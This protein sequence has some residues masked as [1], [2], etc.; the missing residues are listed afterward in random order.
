MSNEITGP[1][2][3]C[4]SQSLIYLS[5]KISQVEGLTCR[6]TSTESVSKHLRYLYAGFSCECGVFVPEQI[7]ATGGLT[8]LPL[9]YVGNLTG[10]YTSQFESI[11]RINFKTQPLQFTLKYS[12]PAMPLQ[13]RA[14]AMPLKRPIPYQAP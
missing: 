5:S 6:I 9:A 3:S 11:R 2:Y 4:V 13:D 1:T 14:S 8:A 10:S 12:S 7:E